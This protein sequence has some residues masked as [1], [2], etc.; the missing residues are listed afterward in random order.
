MT[1]IASTSQPTR[2]LTGGLR[3]GFFG[4]GFVGFLPAP[5][6]NPPQ[7]RFTGSRI[8]QSRDLGFR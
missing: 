4:P 3:T 8:N 7:L 6:R 2:F 1:P 5:G